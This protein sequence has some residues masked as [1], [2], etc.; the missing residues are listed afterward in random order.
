MLYTV[1]GEQPSFPWNHI[2]PHFHN[3][4][5]RA[6]NHIPMPWPEHVRRDRDVYELINRDQN[7][8]FTDENIAK[9]TQQSSWSDRIPIAAFYA[10]FT[11]NRQIV[12]EAA[13]IYPH[14]IHA[15]FDCHGHITLKS[16]NPTAKVLKISAVLNNVDNGTLNHWRSTTFGH[17]EALRL[18]CKRGRDTEEYHAKYKYPGQYKYVIVPLGSWALSTSGRLGRLLAYS[19]CVVL[20]QESSFT[21]HFTARL[22]PWVHYVP[23]SY[24]MVY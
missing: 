21:H 3:A 17:A 19:G 13:R 5:G 16:L 6:Y 23:L 15:H 8:L 4:P 1:G 2:F 20:L 11:E 22:K 10:S 9:V 12:Y 18:Q 14:L 7:G 24:S